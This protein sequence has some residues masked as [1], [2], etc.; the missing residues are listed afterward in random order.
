MQSHLLHHPYCRHHSR[1]R[2]RS[3]SRAYQQ[4]LCSSR[5]SSSSSCRTETRRQRQLRAAGRLWQLR[6]PLWQQLQ[7]RQLHPQQLQQAQSQCPRLLQSHPLLQPCPA[8]AVDYQHSN[9]SAPAA[10]FLPSKAPPL[11]PPQPASWAPGLRPAAASGVGG[12]AVGGRRKS[13]LSLLASRISCPLAGRFH[14]L[15]R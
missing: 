15:R 7:P 10:A 9:P 4:A 13:R 8:S 1:S 3:R 12:G 14:I 11:P 6:M 2:R 5:L